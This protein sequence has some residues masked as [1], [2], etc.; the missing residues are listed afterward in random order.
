[1]L[2][3]EGGQLEIRA[4]EVIVG[5]CDTIRSPGPVLAGTRLCPQVLDCGRDVPGCAVDDD[6]RIPSSLVRECFVPSVEGAGVLDGECGVTQDAGEVAWVFTAQ[7]C[8]ANDLGYAPADD[9][10]RLPVVGVDAVAARLESPGDA[11]A[12]R[13]LVPGEAGSFPEDAGLDGAS[14]VQVFADHAVPLAV[15]LDHPEHDGPV[16][17]NP[18]AWTAEVVADD[19]QVLPADWTLA[20]LL[21][22]GVPAGVDASVQLTGPAGETVTAGRVR[23]IAEAE[24]ATLE[25]V[26]GY[27]PAEEEDGPH[28]P[29]IGARAVFRTADGVPVFGVPVEWGVTAG[30]FPVWRG[31]E[32]AWGPDYVALMDEDGRGCH[33]PPEDEVT[34][35]RGVLTATRADL[36]AE[37]ELRWTEDPEGT[38][39]LAEIGEAFRGDDHRD[40]ELCQGPGF[41]DAGCGCRT[42]GGTPAGLLGLLGLLALRRRRASVR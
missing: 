9:L 5:A 39:L 42:R 41:P 22:V 10:L 3:T 25:V 31:E 23:G 21:V 6:N 12:R 29:P 35:F 38:N 32:Q 15:V 13:A 7:A 18:I 14:V 36:S 1:M 17:W 30:A 11:F 20:G 4:T 40:S 34:A 33:P 16:G 27:A 2:A 19:G 26:A 8:E 37:V 24:L 28:G